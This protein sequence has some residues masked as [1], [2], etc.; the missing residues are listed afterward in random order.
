MLKL[1]PAITYFTHLFAHDSLSGLKV[2]LG[3]IYAMQSNGP[4]YKFFGWMSFGYEIFWT[5]VVFWCEIPTVQLINPAE[6]PHIYGTVPPL[7]KPPLRKPAGNPPTLLEGTGLIRVWIP[8][9]DPY[10]RVPYPKP[11]R[12]Q[13]PLTIPKGL[14]LLNVEC[15][16]RLTNKSRTFK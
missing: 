1:N 4:Q 13:K 12:V 6:M 9:P 10:P 14:G 11:T 15:W 7:R 8:N 3:L 5:D 16:S 2:N